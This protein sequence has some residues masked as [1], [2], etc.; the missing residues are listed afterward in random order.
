M[1]RLLLVIDHLRGGGTEQQTL[2]LTQD[3]LAAGGC[4]D[5]LIFLPGGRLWEKVPK[6][7]DCTVHT[8]QHWIQTDPSAD[9]S[10]SLFSSILR[11]CFSALHLPLWAP[12]LRRALER[13]QP[14]VCVL[15]GRTANCYGGYIRSLLGTV[16]VVATVRTGKFLL[17]WHQQSLRQ[18]DK[19]WT[20]CQW[21]AA[22]L[23]CKGIPAQRIA[24]IHN[25][26]RKELFSGTGAVDN[27]W[28][29]ASLN[30]PAFVSVAGFRRGKRQD[31]LLEAW[32]KVRA[33]LSADETM[34]RLILVGDGPQLR[35]C[36]NLC[37]RLQLDSV[38]QFTG[39]QSDLRPFYREGNV[40][41]SMS[42]EDS[43]PNFLV[44]AQWCGLP[45]IAADCAGVRECF[46]DR[47]SGA[48]IGA[49]DSHG[50]SAW[51]LQL[52]RSPGLLHAWSRSAR[53]FAQSRFHPE[54]QSRR[55]LQMLHQLCHP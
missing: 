28:A 2:L 11:Q 49:G 12:G 35:H 1:K 22:R 38:V 27:N 6:H 14:D 40:A 15:M 36:R 52:Q 34:P 16:P 20:N 17:P 47:G 32:A 45:V 41:V 10:G 18:C 13:L 19:I 51:V 21:W 9:V 24:V 5:L 53:L 37:Q 30:A 4:V 25:A 3:W 23:Q 46:I 50:M 42:R 54:I 55:T 39:W 31:L 44:E 43:L 33:Q 48:L 29:P 8:L 7:P 26:V